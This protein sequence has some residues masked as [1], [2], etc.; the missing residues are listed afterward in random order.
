M[1]QEWFDPNIIESD[2][3]CPACGDLLYVDVRGSGVQTCMT[4]DCSQ[5]V[6]LGVILDPSDDSHPMHREFKESEERLGRLITQSMPRELIQLAYEKRRLLIEGL[7]TNGFMQY[8][9]EWFAAEDLLILTRTYPAR[10]ALYSLVTP[11]Q[12]FAEVVQYTKRLNFFDD[13]LTKRY[14]AIITESGI[15]M[16]LKMKYLDAVS[17][18]L[19]AF[20][21]ANSRHISTHDLFEFQDIEES[22]TPDPSTVEH[23]NDLA[24]VL[25]T[26]WPH[27]IGLNY[28]LKSHYRTSVHHRYT[29]GEFDIPAIVGIAFSLRDNK[30]HLVP[31]SLLREHFE[32]HHVFLPQFIEFVSNYVDCI[33]RVPLLPRIGGSVLVDRLSLLYLAAYLHSLTP[34][35]QKSSSKLGGHRQKA[36]SLFEEKVRDRLRSLS[37]DTCPEAIQEKYEYDAIG[38]RGRQQVIMVEAK[39][40]D[41]TPSSISGETLLEQQLL[42]KDQGLL[43]EAQTHQQRL[44]Y[45]LAHHKRFSRHFSKG[46]AASGIDAQAYIITKQAPLIKRYRDVHLISYS[47]FLSKG[48][49]AWITPQAPVATPC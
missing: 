29:V 21:L 22:V 43:K 15:L 45:F 18:S 41:L 8:D 5:Y 7:V 44:E 16:P 46:L 9:P 26:L 48:D 17:D 30:T 11:E 25:D 28:V 14:V 10:S 35:V 1:K 6:R 3:L 37:Y 24:D 27:L 34:E 39:F 38:A 19:K 32:K 47:E 12:V 31:L 33:E 4:E 42:N 49:D 23:S 2:Y 36:S 20:G 13:L 40:Q